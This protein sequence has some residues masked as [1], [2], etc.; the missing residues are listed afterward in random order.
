MLV[1]QRVP[2]VVSENPVFRCKR[3]WICR[4]GWP[5]CRSSFQS[6]RCHLTHLGPHGPMICSAFLL[7][8][9]GMSW[10]CRRTL[11]CKSQ[12]RAGIDSWH[13]RLCDLSNDRVVTEL[14]HWS[15][16]KIPHE[17]S[18]DPLN[19]HFLAIGATN[20]IAMFALG[21]C[22]SEVDEWH[23]STWFQERLRL[24]GM[25]RRQSCSCWRVVAFWQGQDFKYGAIVQ[26]LALAMLRNTLEL[27]AGHRSGTCQ[28]S[29]LQAVLGH[30]KC[31]IEGSCWEQHDNDSHVF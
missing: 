17:N 9:Q 31:A 14:G 4:A 2:L 26:M 6:P 5:P 24:T 30:Q 18:W 1:H 7:R 25:L 20:A 10:G 27:S 11:T 21:F 16:G 28:P 12:V 15:A 19:A 23:L 13:P 29:C 3:S 8:T 22:W